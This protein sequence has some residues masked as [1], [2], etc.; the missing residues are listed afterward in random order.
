MA[1][2]TELKR[3]PFSV[4]ARCPHAP[5]VSAVVELEGARGEHLRRFSCGICERGWWESDGSVIDL[6]EV[7]DQ[8]R[9]LGRG[10]QKCRTQSKIGRPEQR[11]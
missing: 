4:A 3:P 9:E 7:L 6:D 8:M 10:L 11:C 2:L 5:V 1:S